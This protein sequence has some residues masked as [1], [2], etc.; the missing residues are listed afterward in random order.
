MCHANAKTIT[1]ANILAFG[2]SRPRAW[3][4]GQSSQ[5]CFLGSHRSA[6]GRLLWVALG[7]LGSLLGASWGP[8]GAFWGPL[9]ASWEPLGGLLGPP[10][11]FWGVLG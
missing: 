5:G 6:L 4:V 7:L 1:T 8:L 11:R 2:P 9:G 10:S 3:V